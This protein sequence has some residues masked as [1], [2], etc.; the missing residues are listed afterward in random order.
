MFLLIQFSQIELISSKSVNHKLFLKT[1]NFKTIIFSSKA[2]VVLKKTRYYFS[3]SLRSLIFSNC[4]L[5]MFEF[6]ITVN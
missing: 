1:K 3:V 2:E 6:Q 5:A 4:L